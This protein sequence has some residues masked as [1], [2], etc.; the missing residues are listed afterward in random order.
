M[1]GNIGSFITALAFPYLMS[2]T[3]SEKPFFYV[4]AAL[5]VVA[6][7]A[8]SFMNPSKPIEYRTK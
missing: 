6:M 2:W 8:W 3:G 5:A 4:G 1:A 7:I